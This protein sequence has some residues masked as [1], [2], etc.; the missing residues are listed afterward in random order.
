MG[1][2]KGIKRILIG[3]MVVAV[4][5]IIVYAAALIQAKTRLRT[6]YAALEKDGR[7]MQATD[8]IPRQMP[9]AQNA[10][11]LYQSAARPLRERP[12]GKTNLLAHLGDLSFACIRDALEPKRRAEWEE[13]TAQEIVSSALAALEKAAHY[14]DC[15]FGPL[16]QGDWSTHSVA[17]EELRDLA[18][19]WG[20]R[21][22]M[23]MR[24]GNASQAWDR[25]RLQ[26]EF[27]RALR[28]D[29]ACA[30]QVVR[31]G[32]I[33]DLC[34]VLQRLCEVAPAPEENYREIDR[35]LQDLNDTD[36]LVRAVDAERLLRGEWLFNLPRDQLYQWLRDNFRGKGPTSKL[37][38]GLQFR[39]MTFPPLF[40][41]DHAS[42]LQLMGK[43]VCLLRRPYAPSDADIYREIRGLSVG[44]HPITHH[45]VSVLA[46]D[47]KYHCLTEARLQITRA[48][49][50]LLQYQRSHGSFP[51]GL[52]KLGVEGL[53]DPYAQGPLRYRAAEGS[54][55]VYSVGEDLKDDEG[56]GGRSEQTGGDDIAWQFPPRASRAA[57]T[58]G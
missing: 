13:L 41:A 31:L 48:G 29:L 10:A 40:L 55:V 51:S 28:Q 27:V 23:D 22:C 37:L 44:R 43:N 2:H 14:P 56:R 24:A 18:R 8:V 25:I 20:A 16:R 46:L 30:G 58:G 7:P 6:A 36:S 34:C 9:D 49:M 52:E 38:F 3:I 39:M 15:Q 57:A 17:A 11:L 4:V 19:I 26:F 1:L 33:C 42:Y 50:G 54:F 45:L 5:L 47:K 35:W 32:M 21:V 12:Y 53:I